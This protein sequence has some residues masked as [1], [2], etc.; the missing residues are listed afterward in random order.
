ML[1]VSFE[2]T[3]NYIN[4]LSDSRETN[5]PLLIVIVVFIKSD[6]WKHKR[7]AVLKR[8][9]WKC[10]F[11]GALATQVHHKKYARNIGK[12]PIKWLVSVCNEC[13]D[14]QHQ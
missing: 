2:D 14:F 11:C 6:D 3:L 1:Y 9:N 8:D 13:H 4:D 12:E 7:Y 5:F 10:V